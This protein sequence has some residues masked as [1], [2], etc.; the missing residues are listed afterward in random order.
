MLKK[1]YK[2]YSQFIHYGIIGVSGVILDFIAFLVLYNVLGV[3]PV[4]ATCISVLIGITNNFILNTRYNFKKTDKLLLR[5]LSFLI[6]GLSGLLI[7]MFILA[8]GQ[9]FALD[10]NLM[11]LASLPV[12]VVYQYFLNKSVSFKEID[13]KTTL[14][15]IARKI[16]M[17]NWGL[18]LINLIFIVSALFFVKMIPFETGLNPYDSGPDE[19][20]HYRYNTGFLLE[21][22]RLP[23][24]GEDDIP[25]Y[26]ACGVREFG[27]VTCTYSYQVFP[28]ANYIFSAVIST[29]ATSVSNISPVTGARLAAVVWGIL[30]LNLLYII[31]FRL[32]KRRDISWLIASLALIPQV[33][34]TFS[35]TNQNAHSMAISALCIYS[36]I[37]LFQ[38]R[39]KASIILASLAFGALLPLAKYNYFILVPFIGIV[40]I[41]LGVAKQLTFRLIT[42]VL[43]GSII[44]FIIFSSFWFIRN[45]VLYGDITGQNFVVSEMAKY[46]PL[47]HAAPLNMATLEMVTQMNFFETLYRSF[48]V[49]YGSM[50]HYLTDGQYAVLQLLLLTALAGY[51]CIIYTAKNLKTKIHLLG[52]LL[53]FLVILVFA[54]ALVLFNSVHYNFQ[55]QGRYLYPILAPLAGLLALAYLKD[56][57]VN[58]ILLIL[59]FI[60]LFC[61]FNSL[62]LVMRNYLVT[63]AG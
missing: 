27:L 29:I 18:I 63:Y 23:V 2:K 39:N 61:S 21:K 4:V 48:F 51:G 52:Y 8:F 34:F 56:K 47:G 59:L 22:H 32:T 49:A 6:V 46:A 24:S 53:T 25:L 1:I 41:G 43:V 17:K 36:L 10:V 57:R 26:K 15:G 13:P 55:P 20:V 11:K 50:A 28:A 54:I 16:S 9:V 42:K 40:L 14:V 45:V 3:N 12:I 31:A 58:F 5:Y 62:D 44:A 30:F 33:I 19:S 38:D 35:Y 37:R 60:I 7:S